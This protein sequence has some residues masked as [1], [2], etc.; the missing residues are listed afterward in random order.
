MSSGRL[1]AVF[2]RYVRHLDDGVVGSGV[3]ERAR[4]LHRFGLRVAEVFH[5]AL[6]VC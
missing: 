1:E 4:R 6:L 5:V 3:S 2:V